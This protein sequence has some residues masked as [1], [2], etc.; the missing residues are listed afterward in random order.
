MQI[1]S[2]TAPRKF[3][4]R[5]QA[6]GDHRVR[7]SCGGLPLSRACGKGKGTFN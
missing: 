1:Q 6:R 4:E 7:W 5:D 3:R 2:L